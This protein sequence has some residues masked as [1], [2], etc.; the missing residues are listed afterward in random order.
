MTVA[1]K[2]SMNTSGI[3]GQIFGVLSVDVE[4]TMAVGAVNPDYSTT[5]IT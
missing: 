5:A 1:F 3:G 2:R 4:N